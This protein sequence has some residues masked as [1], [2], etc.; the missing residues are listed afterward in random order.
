M[1]STKNKNDQETHELFP[2]GEWEGFYTYN[3]GPSAEQHPMSIYLNFKNNLISGSGGDD[4]G[5][6]SWEGHYDTKQLSC[7]LIKSYITHV[8]LYEG[9][10]DQNGIWGSWTIGGYMKGGFHIWPKSNASNNEKEE[11]EMAPQQK[12]SLKFLKL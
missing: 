10:V 3:Y 9:H 4:V 8:V 6:F 5:A 12:E 7:K 1:N 11:I 2:S